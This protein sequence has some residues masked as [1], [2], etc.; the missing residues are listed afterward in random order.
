MG[1]NT[2]Y[3]G[4]IEAKRL[5]LSSPEFVYDF[6]EKHTDDNL[7]SEIFETLY[8]LNNELINL[9][10]AR[11]CSNQEIL[12]RIFS[13]ALDKDGEA[14]RCA[15]LSNVYCKFGTHLLGTFDIKE[16]KVVLEKA[17]GAEIAAIMG[18]KSLTGSFLADIIKRTGIAENLTDEQ[19][20]LC[21]I[22]A[23]NLNPNLR[24]DYQSAA[25]TGYSEGWED[26][27][28]GKAIDAAW[29]LL[30]NAPLT[31]KW[32]INLSHLLSYRQ[33]YL[34][35]SCNDDYFQRIFSR[36]KSDNPDLERHFGDLRMW[37][38]AYVPSTLKLHKWMSDHEDKYIRFGHYYSFDTNDP[39]EL[40]KYYSRDGSDFIQIANS[41]NNLF[42][43]KEVRN[44]LRELIDKDCSTSS[45]WFE[46]DLF[47]IHYQN[48]AKSDPRYL[49]EEDR[50]EIEASQPVTAGILKEKL[51]DLENR[52]MEQLDQKLSK[53]KKTIF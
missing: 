28:H 36:W 25:P 10:L 12:K 43:H 27:E 2:K 48:L 30:E 24:Q 37:V 29:Q 6:L 41:N 8:K 17:T 1:N 46:L 32:A 49:S 13:N 53:L 23:L 47:E 11:F 18:S 50:E 4:L 35:Y 21:C 19:W 20:F 38:G 15:M 22:H 33:I 51:E 14:I 34:P 52:L 5:F 42:G 40:E 44:K 39:S 7:P 3:H 9:G 45:D 26:Y 31:D 16:Q